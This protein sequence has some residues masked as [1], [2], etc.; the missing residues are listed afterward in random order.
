M[1]TSV[2]ELWSKLDLITPMAVRVAAT[3]RVADLIAAGHDDLPALAAKAGSAGVDETALGR[4]LRYLIARGIFVEPE[5]GRFALNDLAE[6]LLDD[7]PTST[8]GWLDLDGFG[9]RMDLAFFDL[10]D[11]VRSGR[12][13]VTGHEA[14]LS[15]AESESYDSVMEAQSRAQ[16]PG[17]SRAYDW[18]RFARVI[19]VGGGTGT[20]LAELLR[21]NP[22]LR[23]TLLDLPKAAAKASAVF[24]E[25][26]V[27]ERAEA[28]GGDLFEVMPERGDVYVLKF[29]LHFLEDDEA[30]HALTR[31]REARAASG[32][33]VVIERSVAPGDDRKDFTAMDMRMLILGHGR[34]RTVDEYTALAARAGLAVG[35]VTTTVD[36]LHLIEL[37]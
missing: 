27:G 21:T 37:V 36:D 2:Q 31:C 18:S 3:L 22:N 26:G 5:R 28:I 11:V 30:V 34:E 8:R 10:L 7:H 25:A 19:D 1:D 20:L 6:V 33:V 29:V 32:R 12:P 17:I 13:E 24:A 14:N 4:L 9:G 15:D 35:V 23:G 16:A